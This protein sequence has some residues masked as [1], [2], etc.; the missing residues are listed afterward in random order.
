MEV[1]IFLYNVLELDIEIIQNSESTSS[2]VPKLNR[3]S[4]D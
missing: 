1:Q 3:K 4:G 2:A